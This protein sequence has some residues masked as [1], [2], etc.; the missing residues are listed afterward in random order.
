LLITLII[1]IFVNLCIHISYW[2]WSI[3]N[4][5]IKLNRP[6]T[7]AVHIY[8]Y[9]LIWI[10]YLSSFVVTSS[11]VFYLLHIFLNT[12]RSTYIVVFNPTLIVIKLYFNICPSFWNLRN[13][14]ALIMKTISIKL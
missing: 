13:R 5:I 12:T 9:S 11:I 7:L 6:N 10:N 8:Q 2:I 14:L 4:I 3:C 1:S